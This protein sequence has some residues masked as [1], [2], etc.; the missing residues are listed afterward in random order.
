MDN[1][2]PKQFSVHFCVCCVV[3]RSILKPTDVI[4]KDYPQE[5]YEMLIFCQGQ[6]SQTL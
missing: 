2:L 3:T 6:T 5:L 4:T 1:L